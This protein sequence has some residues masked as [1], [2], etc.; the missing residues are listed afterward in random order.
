MNV[1]SP[2]GLKAISAVPGNISSIEGETRAVDE[3]FAEKILESGNH[4]IFIH[5]NT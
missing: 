4:S 5:P 2:N 3:F 1:H